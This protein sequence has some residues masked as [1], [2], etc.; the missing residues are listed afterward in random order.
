MRQH[1]GMTISKAAGYAHAAN[2]MTQHP[3]EHIR[4]RDTPE[5]SNVAAVGW[6][7]EMRMYARFKSG[8]I[9]MY[10]GVSRQRSVACSRAKSVGRYF[11]QFIK[12]N[13]KAVKIA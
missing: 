10:E 7:S 12:P 4:W 8:S 3:A 11:H 6:D 13:Y 2:L 5:S 9:Y 1:L